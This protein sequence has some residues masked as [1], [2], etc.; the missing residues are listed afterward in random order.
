MLPQAEALVPVF[1]LWCRHSFACLCA[2]VPGELVS[3]PAT[4]EAPQKGV[5]CQHEDVVMP[6]HHTAL[7]FG[8]EGGHGQASA[9]VQPGLA[10]L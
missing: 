3:P 2:K 9:S 6:Q 8:I 4:S 5:S 1:C 7:G 10:L